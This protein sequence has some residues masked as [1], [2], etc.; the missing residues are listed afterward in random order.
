M[1][2]DL[3][4]ILNK[5]LKIDDDLY[6]ESFFKTKSRYMMMEDGGTYLS[7]V[8]SIVNETSI[9]TG[10]CGGSNGSH[11][12]NLLKKVGVQDHLVEI[13]VNS[14]EKLILDFKDKNIVVSQDGIEI[15]RDEIAEFYKELKEGLNNSE[16]I[17][18]SGTYPSN[19]PD[20]MPVD[21]V[22]FAKKWGRKIFVAP[23]ISVL[24]RVVDQAPDLI[25]L[26]KE[27]L[28][29]LTNLQ[30]DFEGETIRACQYLFHNG[31]KY[32]LVD[33]YNNGFLIMDKKNG[34]SL[35]IEKKKDNNTKLNYGA[36]LA[37]FSTGF[38]RNYDFETTAKLSYACG[39]LDFNNNNG[40]IDMT[41][42]K[43][44]MNQINIRSFHNL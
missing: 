43:E 34:Y 17:C 18:L 2:I 39:L 37:G 15:S 16:I 8:L 19:M 9:L 31:I 20:E 24:G 23:E 40:N 12:R 11:I 28:E 6:D 25:L 41:D 26:D 7:I 21:I 27:G 10:F 13:S 22:V 14:S 42:I 29:V 32:V 3:N 30:L 38:K 36:V 44:L 35:N 4:P 5:W 33:M 1:S